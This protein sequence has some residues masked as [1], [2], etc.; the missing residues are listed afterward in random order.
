MWIQFILQNAHFCLNLLASLVAFSV[1]WLYF[2]AY[3]VRKSQHELFKVLGFLLL[4]VSFVIQSTFIEVSILP[5]NFLTGSLSLGS[6]S[7]IRLIAYILIAAGLLFDPILPRPKVDG[8]VKPN[9]A[10]IGGGSSFGILQI[11]SIG[12]PILS[13]LIGLLYLRRATLGLENHL[14]PLSLAFFV[15]GFYELFHLATFLQT[16]QNI[17]VYKLVVSFGPLWLLSH[18]LLLFFTAILARWVFGYLLTRLQ[19]QLFIF[20]TASILGIFM[21]TAVAF[22][23]LLLRNIQTET[24]SRITTD[25]NVLQYAI[26]SK[27]AQVISDAQVLSQHPQVAAALQNN[28]PA[29]LSNF[30]DGFLSAKKLNQ[31]V[32]IDKSSQVLVRGGQSEK[33]GDF[34]TDNPLLARALQAE[35]VTSI[36]TV[37]GAVVPELILQSAV[38][39]SLNNQVIGAVLIGEK[40]DNLFM[41]GIKNATTLDASIY[42][43]NKLAATTLLLQDGKSRAL[44]IKETDPQVAK[45]VL[46]K[47]QSYTGPVNILNVPY[48]SAYLALKDFNGKVVGMLSVSL[49]QVGVLQLIG[50]SLELTFITTAILIL[51][52]IVPAF[53]IS[54]YIVKQIK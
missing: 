30:T 17:E 50:R 35:S 11:L 14:K 54:R 10:I 31:L 6:A 28:Q 25:A 18:G 26:E 23:F 44:G 3:L 7:I 2:D 21:V 41:D 24:L 22:T 27:R 47:G 34:L 49:P 15:L 12:L 29:G 36:T 38:P 32:I 42:S 39:V 46:E 53:F 4:S 13:S 8:L 33:S 45:I 5:T 9:Q 1:F 37:E 51:L 20:Y 16:T 48:Y 40:I 19:S 43:G 52:S